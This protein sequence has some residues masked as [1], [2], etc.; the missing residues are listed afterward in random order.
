MLEGLMQNDFQLNVG[1][2]RRRLR[3][4]YAD[5]QVVTMTADGYD[6]ASYG[7][8]AD[9]VDRLGRVLE[10]LGVQP[11]DRVATFAWN[12]QRHFELYLAVPSYGAVLHTLNIRLFPE[13][14][15]YIVGHAR[16]EVVFVDGSLVEPL[17]KLAGQFE[18]VRQY[19]VM[20]DGDLDALPNSVSY[21]ELLADAGDGAYDWPDVPERAAAALCY[22]SGTTGNPK[23]VLYSH[24]SVSM[25]STAQCLADGVGLSSADTVLAIVPMFHVNAWGLPFGA[26]LTG[27][28]L[29]MPGPYLQGEPLAR[30]V[31][32]ER[33]TLIAGVPTVLAALL[34]H[35]DD[36]GGDLSSLRGGVCGGAAVPR[37]LMEGF[38][39]HGVRVLQAWGM[40]ETSPVCTVAR[41][42]AGAD[43]GEE[44]WG[45]RTTV[46]RPVPWV[47]LALS[48]DNSEI[49]VR[50][51]WIAARYYED[52]S[53]DDKFED[54]WLR[55]G[56]IGEMD[57]KG[58]VRITDR[59]K[60]LIKSGGEWISSVEVETL[61]MGHP[62]V[63]EAAVIGMPDERWSERPLACVALADGAGATPAELREHLAAAL[64]KWQ[65]PDAFVFIDEVPKT[66]VGKFDKKVLR[67]QL[68]DGEL[69]VERPDKVS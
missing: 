47:E 3:S 46:G 59:S 1:A 31:A 43:E 19:V 65:L 24:R 39:R 20:G 56:D 54:G 60:D 53:G 55:T 8:V 23:G 27:A 50:G 2:I 10:R 21:E 33:P 30:F 42:P 5:Q 49:M 28:G 52:P 44:H 63:R 57:E 48:D 35:V 61:L 58:F 4:C 40:T 32:Q 29:H 7:E 38:E 11:G 34:E 69:V 67:R 26:A 64:A 51:P 16:D 37:K 13:Q 6:R 17:A 12:T 66:S 18:G 41:P 45:Y 62:D 25:H 9:R 15:A 22:T 36:N 68:A 14:I